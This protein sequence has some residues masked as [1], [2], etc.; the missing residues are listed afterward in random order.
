MA[1]ARGDSPSFFRGLLDKQLVPAKISSHDTKMNSLKLLLSQLWL[2]P[3]SQPLFVIMRRQQS[4]IDFNPPR[5]LSINAAYKE[6]IAGQTWHALFRGVSG[7]LVKETFK[8]LVYKGYFIT[9]APLLAE[10]LFSEEVLAQLSPVQH[11]FL[12]SFTASVIASVADAILGNPFD[13][14]VNFRTTSQNEHRT[15]SYWQH[16]RSAPTYMERLKLGNRGWDLSLARSFAG[17]IPFF[18]AAQPIKIGVDNMFDVQPGIKSPPLALLVASLLSGGLSAAT[19]SIFDVARTHIHRAG[20]NPN[21][22]AWQ[23]FAKIQE[24]HGWRGATAGLPIK[25]LQ[26]LLTWMVRYWVTQ[27]VTAPAPEQRVSLSPR[28]GS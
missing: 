11:Y 12:R 27:G 1:A 22:S 3:L 9:K 23:A 20:A 26:N 28:Q 4:A 7:G 19:S 13:A 5:F 25:L 10:N 6:L 21:Q 14:Y 15:A 18:F 17:Y 2:I 24:Q 8:I 16:L